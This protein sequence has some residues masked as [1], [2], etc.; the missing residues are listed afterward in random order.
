MSNPFSVNFKATIKRRYEKL[1]V[2]NQHYSK[3]IQCD[4]CQ[5]TK[6]VL[7]AFRNENELRL[8][9]D[10]I[11]Q[12][13]FFSNVIDNSTLSFNSLWS[14]VQCRLPQNIFNFTVRYIS[15][16]LPS[17]K[18]LVKWGLS[19]ST[20]CSFCCSPE[21]LLHIISGCKAYLDEG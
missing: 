10:L 21:S 20:D 18:N 14:S 3:N 9:N 1:M 6:D 17:R 4:I 13:S 7:K 19:S 16:S 2:N 15:N 5:N 12:G 8:K 11:S